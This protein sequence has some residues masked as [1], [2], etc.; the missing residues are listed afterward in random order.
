MIK[1]ALAA[2]AALA[3]FLPAAANAELAQGATAPDFTTM[4]ALAGKPMKVNLKA[5]L[6]KGPVVLYFYPKAFTSGCTME[7]HAFAEATAE[8]AKA[9]ATVLGMSNDDLPTLQKFSTAE[10]RDKFT[11]AAASKDVIKAYDVSLSV[12]GVST[13]LT[14]RTSYVIAQDGKIVMVHSDMD[15]RDHVKLT[16]EA[17]QKL[18][19]AG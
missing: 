12:A 4:G 15:Y 8:F 11:V 18:K 16:L 7:A 1:H 9:G 13:G 10:C 14:K 17:V 6:A 5:L 2:A 19:T 3:L